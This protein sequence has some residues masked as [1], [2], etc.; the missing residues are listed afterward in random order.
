VMRTGGY[1]ACDATKLLQ[2]WGDTGRVA[3][4]PVNTATCTTTHTHKH[5]LHTLCLEFRAKQ[6]HDL[7]RGPSS[8]INTKRKEGGDYTSSLQLECWRVSARL[9]V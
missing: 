3:P 2:V 7:S 1:S 5:T 4:V 9:R 8:S 6:Q